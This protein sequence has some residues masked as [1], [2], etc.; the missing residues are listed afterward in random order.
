MQIFIT[1]VDILSFVTPKYRTLVSVI[2]L[3]YILQLS[4]LNEFF[5]F[6][7]PSHHH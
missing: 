2:G 4:T 1:K 5:F 3:I 7:V 6:F